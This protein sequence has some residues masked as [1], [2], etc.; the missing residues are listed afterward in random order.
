MLCCVFESYTLHETPIDILTENEAQATLY[1]T[2]YITT[3]Y[4]KA[5]RVFCAV[6]HEAQNLIN[7][8]FLSGNSGKDLAIYRFLVLLF[9]VGGRAVSMLGDEAVSNINKL[10]LA[11]S[12]E[13]HL[14]S[15]FVR[16][17]DYDGSLVALIEPSIL[18][19]RL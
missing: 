16:F 12:H 5:C 14:M 11:V 13:A 7:L 4:T 17:S 8:A 10:A 15:G 3:D 1:K 18:Y 6:V 2:R 19:C 9:K